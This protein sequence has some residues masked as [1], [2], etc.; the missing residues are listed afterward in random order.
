MANIKVISAQNE[1]DFIHNTQYCATFYNTLESRSKRTKSRSSRN[2]D[3]MVTLDDL[4][5]HQQ[6]LEE[7]ARATFEKF[8]SDSNGVLDKGEFKAALKWMFRKN[9][10]YHSSWKQHWNVFNTD[11][12]QGITFMEF[13]SFLN[14]MRRK[15]KYHNSFE[16]G[17]AV[18]DSISVPNSAVKESESKLPLLAQKSTRKKSKSVTLTSAASRE[19]VLKLP[20]LNSIA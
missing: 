1:R 18:A 12:Y 2:A 11:I 17:K 9:K 6:H 4:L 20:R 15:K 16:N 5:R 3:A 8:D 7:V 13:I 14:E 10:K 19:S